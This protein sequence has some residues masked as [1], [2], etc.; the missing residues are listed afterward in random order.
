MDQTWNTQWKYN[1]DL[2]VGPLIKKVFKRTFFDR[3]FQIENREA[4]VEEF[5]NLPQ[6]GMSV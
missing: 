2:R 4:K 1:R 6:G 3:F 5:I